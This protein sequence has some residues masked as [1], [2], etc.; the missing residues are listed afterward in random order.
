MTLLK[1]W[2]KGTS[3]QR[4]SFIYAIHCFVYFN[5]LFFSCYITIH[6]VLSHASTAEALE[7]GPTTQTPNSLF[8][9]LSLSLL[10]HE[11]NRHIYTQTACPSQSLSHPPCERTVSQIAARWTTGHKLDFWQAWLHCLPPRPAPN[12][13]LNYSRHRAA[14]LWLATQRGL[15][16][17]FTQTRTLS[18]S[19]MLSR[20]YSAYSLT[21]S[22]IAA[23]YAF[24]PRLNQLFDLGLS[25]ALVM[26]P[27][28]NFLYTQT[29]NCMCKPHKGTLQLLWDK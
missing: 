28:P 15:V 21:S 7:S 11:H 27:W 3:N 9:F 16:S 20:L 17:S 10:W 12:P 29:W 14:Q 13:E 6:V 2:G 5:Y 22:L 19:V 4:M 26:T 23:H 25:H 18:L 1:C 24:V 8:L